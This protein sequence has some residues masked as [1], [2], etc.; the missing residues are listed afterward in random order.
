MSTVLPG[1]QF[2]A[3][4][5]FATPSAGNLPIDPTPQQAGII[6][7]LS[8]DI[9]GDIKSL[10]GQYQWPVDSAIG[11]REIKGT[12]NFAQITN[13]FLNQLFFADVITP[14]TI[15][16]AYQEGPTVIP[17]TPY[18]I[19]VT[20]SATFVVDQGVINTTTGVGMIQVA[21]GPITGQYSV[22]AGVYTFAAADAGTHVL[23]SYGWT[24]A[25]VGSTLTTANHVMGW[26]PVV[27]MTIPFLY[28]SANFA[29]NLPN[30]RLGKISIK[31][32]LD[33]YAMMSTEFAAFAG[34]GQ[35]PI[36]FYNLD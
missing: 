9:S 20:H 22:A 32:K 35:N 1:I 29:M 3:G 8:V 2:G 7:D 30:A 28:E 14:G 23:I 19:T 18:E 10:F 4:I 27:N 36:N 5:I 6:Q 24:A 17:T 12:F 13:Q 33:D 34:A 21:S 25:S 11:K 16:T 31:T 15:A 26:G